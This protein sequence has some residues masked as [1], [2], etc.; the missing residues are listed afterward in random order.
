VDF[1]QAVTLG[2]TDR[3]DEFPAIGSDD[4]GNVWVS[5]VAFDGRADAVFAAKIAGQ[6]AAAPVVLSEA[7]GDHWR[8]AM[9][10]DGKGHLWV[11][12][13]R[14]DQG[15]WDIWGKFLAAG[16]WSEAIQ[17]TRGKGND[18]GQKLAVDK[19]GT[20]WMTWQSVVN[21][22]YEVLLAPITPDGSGE[23]LNVSRHP[24]SDWEPAIA[25]AKDGR[26]FVAWDSY[27]SGSYDILVAE[28]KDGKV[29]SAREITGSQRA[30]AIVGS[31]SRAEPMGIAAS[32]A[33]EAHAT[34]AVDHQDRLW[35]AWDNGG[36]RWGE[37][38]D[39]GRKLHG[40]RSVEIRCLANGE[41]AE[42]A[43]PLSVA[44]SGPLT[45]F[46]ELPELSID[47]SGKLWLI[48]RH[49]TNLTPKGTRDGGRPHQD[50]GMWNPYV[51]CYDGSRWSQPQQLPDGNG[52][53]DMRATTC[54]DRDGRAWV[55]W[56][57]DGRT[58]AKP[59]EPQNHNVHALPLAA[60]GADKVVLK[61]VTRGKVSPAPGSQEQS[62]S[63]SAHPKLTVG[64]RELL[65]AYGDT[66]RH[67][68]ISQCG[69]NRDGS[70]MDTYRYAIDVAKLD[71]LAISDHDQDILKHRSNRDKSPLQHYA[72]WRSEKYCDLF[73]IENK[74]IPLYAYEHGR[75]GTQGGHKNVLYADRG[76]PCY[77][78][79]MPD[80]LFKALKGKNAVAIPHQLADGPA[81]T[82]WKK[83]NPEF[84]RV[85][86]IFQ[87]RGSYEY[88]GALP[89]VRVNRDGHYY[90]DAL[91]ME[92]RIGAIASSDHGMVHSAYAGVY[93]RE[94]TRAGVMEG[95][96]SRRTFGSMDRMVIEF[97][98]GERLLGE[99]VDVSTAP[100][101]NVR[102]ESPK[103][104][105][106]VQIVKNGKEIH[107]VNPDAVS[108]R[109]EYVDREIQPGHQA[110][111]YIRCEQA[112]N[113]NGWS[114]PIWVGWK[115]SDAK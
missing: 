31:I 12:W 50:R 71:F 72:W 20:L 40:E 110:W 55:S 5:W 77:E 93:C 32:P 113:R 65:L 33:Y 13:T 9:C 62:A 23:A 105:R 41:L 4:A 1:K 73:Y 74:F 36:V 30:T 66:H 94:L 34:L 38:N 24:A 52:R 64:G 82:D 46:C 2:S 29:S 49:L 45:N 115:S 54:L 25:A 51:L 111:Y 81:A 104:L 3:E 88:K 92:V 85:A 43:E 84:E 102:V 7:V 76:Q 112:D 97:R 56:A 39:D 114:S 53:N 99:E 90:R 17:L 22:N 80:E 109:F 78:E 101:F 18:F 107:T 108:S 106:K 103:P 60:P 21:G 89:P 26:V 19:T 79:N 35:I 91:E 70:L 83:W 14:N 58:A 11:T 44:L 98:L 95:L 75:A 59:P 86:E 10:K 68:D 63:S 42:P 47:G 57:D 37:D 69:M 15:Q 67:T 96:R 100:A 16:K 27:R 61:T 28:L 48:V 6:T 8:P 87:A